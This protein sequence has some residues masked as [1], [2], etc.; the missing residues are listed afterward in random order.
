MFLSLAVMM[1]FLPATSDAQE[2]QPVQSFSRH[3][4]DN[5]DEMNATLAAYT[6]HPD[7]DSALNGIHSILQESQKHDFLSG[8]LQ[9]LVALGNYYTRYA[10]HDSALFYYREALL[11]SKSGDVEDKKNISTIF[12][13]IANI[14]NFQGDFEA[15]AKMYLQALMTMEVYGT[16]T[17]KVTMYTNFSTV[18][19]QLDMEEQAGYY[20]ELAERIA[21]KER[22]G[23]LT[24]I[25]LSKGIIAGKQ[26]QLEAS[27]YYFDSA[28]ILARRFNQEDIKYT[29]LSNIG[30]NYYQQGQLERALPILMEIKENSGRINPY[31]VTHTTG[32]IGSI[33]YAYKE[34]DKAEHYLTEA[35]QSAEKMRYEN[36]L[37]QIHRLLARTYTAQHKYRQA[38][39]HSEAYIELKEKL[40]RNNTSHNV[41]R[42]QIKYRTVEKDKELIEQQLFIAKQDND[43]KR[44]NILIVS[45]AI[46]A[47]LGVSFFIYVYK[48]ART[49]Q[50][51]QIY[52]LRRE[53]EIV[54]EKEK[55]LKQEQ[56][57]LQLKAIMQ[58]EENERSRIAR[59]LHDGLGSIIAAIKLNLG[60]VSRKY[61][62]LPHAHILDDTEQLINNMATE[63]RNIAH[64]LMPKNLLNN[65]LEEALLTY[66]N[67]INAGEELQID[68]H[69]YGDFNALTNDAK[70]G[71]YRI[72]QELVQNIIKHANA[73][74]AVIQLLRIK[75]SL[76]ITI[77]DDGTGFDMDAGNNGIGLQNVKLRVQ[78]LQGVISIQSVAE[79]STTIYMEFNFDFLTGKI[80]VQLIEHQ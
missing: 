67:M 50:K 52:A 54:R 63:V 29:I 71:I 37:V 11:Y 73:T 79:K 4:Y 8:M 3:F 22:D 6:H 65:S 20:L 44:K 35:L 9:A 39:S 59:E 80:P 16:Y 2:R 7:R 27:K 42:L 55:N 48:S 58:G 78:A 61:Q 14:Y 76:R 18:L 51:K 49:K 34:Y 1:W 33:Y 28:L 45:G 17:S 12:N 36:H 60:A 72:I 5:A 77:E 23:N 43:I 38:L 24:H 62:N 69:T 25:F 47:I 26:Q 31:Y 41:A 13:N 19:N 30:V 64:N 66:R 68:L 15:A 21:R 46:M 40:D 70:L 57:I 75:D 56:E 10:T 74:T 53:Q 32:I